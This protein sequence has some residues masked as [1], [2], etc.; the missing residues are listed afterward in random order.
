MSGLAARKQHPEPEMIA[1]P[2]TDLMAFCASHS[3]LN[4]LNR[5]KFLDW[6][7]IRPQCNCWSKSSSVFR[8]AT[9]WCAGMHGR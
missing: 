5:P 8:L 1:I 7:T 6:H 3:C 4:L 2:E 9:I